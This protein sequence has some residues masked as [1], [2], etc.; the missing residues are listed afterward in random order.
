MGGEIG[1][2]D[3]GTFFKWQI[4]NVHVIVLLAVSLT[5][6]YLQ[7]WT[8]LKFYNECTYIEWSYSDYQVHVIDANTFC[9]RTCITRINEMHSVLYQRGLVFLVLLFMPDVIFSAKQLTEIY[10][11]CIN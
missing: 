7:N 1:N 2:I 5:I 4:P 8:V 9:L 11:V 10:S 6:V 3:E